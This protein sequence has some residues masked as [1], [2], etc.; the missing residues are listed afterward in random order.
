MIN[1]VDIYLVPI[2]ILISGSNIFSSVSCIPFCN[3][4][5]L[6]VEYINCI[7]PFA[8]LF[9]LAFTSKLLSAFIK[10]YIKFSSTLYC[11]KCSK[12]LVL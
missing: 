3:A 1:N 7:N 12:F 4:T 6:A 2:F 5:S 8:S 10:A 11:S 9:D